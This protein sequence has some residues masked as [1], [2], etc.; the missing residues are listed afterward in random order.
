M[1]TSQPHGRLTTRVSGVSN[2]PKQFPHDLGP[3]GPLNIPFLGTVTPLDKPDSKIH[4]KPLPILY[5]LPE[6][7]PTPRPEGFTSQVSLVH[8]SR[9]GLVHAAVTAALKTSVHSDPSIHVHSHTF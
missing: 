9:I 3:A 4:A 6:A 2:V 5:P 7:R 1:R 8:T